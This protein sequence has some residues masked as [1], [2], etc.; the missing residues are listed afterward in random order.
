MESASGE[1]QCFKNENRYKWKIKEENGL[2][3]LPK[4][5]RNQAEM[6]ALKKYYECRKKELESEAADAVLYLRKTDKI[7]VSSE[8]LLNHPEYG[9]LLAKNFRPLNRELE[10]WQEEPYEKSTKHPEDLLVLGNLHGKMLLTKLK[11]LLTEC[12]FKIKYRST[13]KKISFG[14]NY[15]YPDYMTS[16]HRTIF[17]L[18]VLWNDGCPLGLL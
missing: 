17:L 14:W 6:L 1:L 11:Q 3:C 4:T 13:M 18:G 7:K 16:N 12:C 2:R 9:R 5:E 15:L 8:Y 10:R